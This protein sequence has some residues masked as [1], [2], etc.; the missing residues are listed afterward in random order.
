M[1]KTKLG[2]AAAMTAAVALPPAA[3]YAELLQPVPNAVER[4][5]Q[6]D[7]EAAQRPRVMKAQ[8]VTAHHHHHHHHQHHR[9]HRRYYAPPPPPVAHH[10]HHHHHH[11]NNYYNGGPQ[12]D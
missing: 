9:R 11:Q 4:L 1:D 5:Q 10:H 7:A 6:A 8:Y 12:Q 2:L 3:S